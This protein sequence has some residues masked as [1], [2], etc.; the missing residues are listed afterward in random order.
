MG[1][2]HK[3]VAMEWLSRPEEIVEV[4]AYSYMVIIHME[5]FRVVEISAAEDGK[6]MDYYTREGEN[7]K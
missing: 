6:L 2:N 5:R 4:V 7:E 3:K 1:T